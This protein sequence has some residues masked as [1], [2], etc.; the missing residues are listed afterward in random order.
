MS[1]RATHWRTL[2][3][4]SP[5]VQP[6]GRTSGLPGP[7]PSR[8]AKGR[9]TTE[10]LAPLSSSAR[11]GVPLIFTATTILPSLS[12][13]TCSAFGSQYASDALPQSIGLKSRIVCLA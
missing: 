5:N 6:A 3:A 10:A 11:A 12:I 7:M 9:E 2:S 4:P 8:S 1:N 13:G